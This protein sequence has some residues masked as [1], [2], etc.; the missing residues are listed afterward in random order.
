M[1][2]NDRDFVGALE[3]GLLV[4]ESFDQTHA[5]QTLSDVAR[6][7]GMTRAAARRYLLT[8]VR[9]GYAESNGKLFWLIPKVLRLGYALL[10]TT[11]LPKL[12]QPIL[13]RIGE[14]THEIATIAIREGEGAIFLA[15][16]SSRRMISAS[17]AVGMRIP[18]YCS[19]AGKAILAE[20]PDA[21]IKRFLR[22]H[23]FP[24][25]TPQTKTT[26]DEL[27]TELMKV[28]ADGFAV[29][30]QEFELGLRSIAVAVPDSRGQVTLA[31]AVSLHAGRMTVEQLIQ[32]VLPELQAG[33]QDLI[34]M[35]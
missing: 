23:E 20:Q 31:I 33:R 3:K 4:I 26:F 12:A 6:H 34:S 18:L 9:L 21:D 7:T 28:R 10:A 16:S 13:D 1:V 8:L 15:H 30:D 27:W 2:G 32:N 17:T 5:K 19:A 29:S 22:Y 24:Q 25:L 11:P 14:R 35:L